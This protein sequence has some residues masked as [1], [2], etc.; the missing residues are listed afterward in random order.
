ME[1]KTTVERSARGGRRW[2]AV[3]HTLRQVRSQYCCA[4]ITASDEGIEI[5][6]WP[7]FTPQEALEFAA[8]VVIA[9][10]QA[11][12]IA[13]GRADQVADDVEAELC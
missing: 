2:V 5:Q 8:Q 3:C 13:A 4:E 1:F 12:E 6:G 9:A 7:V 11:D 10:A